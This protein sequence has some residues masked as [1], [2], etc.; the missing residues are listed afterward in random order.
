MNPDEML[1]ASL[2][3]T[4]IIKRR[5]TSLYTFGVT[6]L[7]YIFVAKSEI[8]PH[9]TVVREGR[10]MVEKPHILIPGYH[11]LFEGFD[12]EGETPLSGEDIKYILMAR[13]I[14]MPSLR[15]INTAGGLA[16]DQVS[17]DVKVSDVCNRLEGRNDTQTGVIRGEDRFFPFPLLIYVSEMIQRSAGDNL[18]EYLERQGG[19]NP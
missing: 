1:K 18:S 19:S 5:R 11:P 6:R 10:V 12:L 17:L 14:V 9:D 4:A 16:V 15:Y 7:P 3:T 2:E 13:R 8:D